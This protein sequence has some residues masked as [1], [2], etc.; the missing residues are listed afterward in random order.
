MR[1]FARLW[2]WWVGLRAV[3]S[4][5]GRHAPLPS[6]GHDPR[7]IPAGRVFQAFASWLP[8]KKFALAIL[9]SMLTAGWLTAAGHRNY[10]LR[11]SEVLLRD[12]PVV[13]EAVD[14]RQLPAVE[15]E[16]LRRDFGVVPQS[17]PFLALLT[18]YAE[19]QQLYRQ[20]SA[21]L[22]KGRYNELSALIDKAEQGGKA[23]VALLQLRGV[24]QALQALRLHC[25]RR[26]YVAAEDLERALSAL[27]PYGELLKDSAAFRAFW[28]GEGELLE[29]L[30]DGEREVRQSKLLDRLDW[31]LATMGMESQCAD[32]LVK[33]ALEGNATG[34][35]RLVSGTRQCRPSSLL[36]GMLADFADA[37]L[38]LPEGVSPRDL[39]LALAL[40]WERL[41]PAQRRSG[42]HWLDAVSPVT[43]T[44]QAMQ[45]GLRKSQPQFLSALRRWR[46]QATAAQLRSRAPAFLPA[47][48]QT[49]TGGKGR[50]GSHWSAALPGWPEFFQMTD[51]LLGQPEDAPGDRN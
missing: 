15:V 24:P 35:L 10:D 28:Q 34:V 20:A 14:G 46:S 44:A 4:G 26:P 19:Q 1:P 9:S 41:T 3:I 31:A 22:E 7:K 40:T 6:V 8:L 23:T 16:R 42:G 45:A 36:S 18:A 39:E 29:R 2:A 27:E 43:L 21:L 38:I 37:E 51:D 49:A 11:G 25:A 47:M 13:L 33:L 50:G 48:L 5:S 12:A 30:R 17:G 32:I